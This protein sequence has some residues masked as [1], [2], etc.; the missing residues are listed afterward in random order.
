MRNRPAFAP[1]GAV[2]RQREYAGP[3]KGAEQGLHRTGRLATEP[4]I[5]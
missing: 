4:P 2:T 1:C 3:E 5:L